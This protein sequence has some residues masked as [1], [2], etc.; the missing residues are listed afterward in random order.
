MPL[1][2]IED[3][4]G[5]PWALWK[6]EE[7]EEVLEK[8]SLPHEKIPR[9]I[10]HPHK[11]LEWYAA[12]ALVKSLMH[13]VGLTF[14][15]IVKNEYGKPFPANS[16]W[17]LSLSH[18]YPYVAAYLHATASVGIDIQH[19]RDSLARIAPRIL[20]PSEL[21]D[22]GTGIAK[23]CVFWCAKEVLVKVHGKKDL[24]FAENLEISPFSLDSQG[25]LSGNIIVNGIK[26]TVP[27][28]YEIHPEFTLVLNKP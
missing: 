11:R 26:T 13:H 5:N 12:R 10:N 8:G 21:A 6:I 9:A 4:L 19:P 22:S 27:L 18:S 15:G 2:K 20:N 28:Y 25:S 24:V 17:N 14:Q 3:N 23:L 7:S 1:Q 16:S